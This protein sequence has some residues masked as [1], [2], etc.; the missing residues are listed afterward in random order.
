MNR[1]FLSWALVGALIAVLSCAG[2]RT[3]DAQDGRSAPRQGGAMRAACGKDMQSLC[4]GLAGKDAAKCLMKEHR[5]QL[6]AECLTF[7]KEARARRNATQAGAAPPPSG[8][9]NNPAPGA[10]E[11]VSQH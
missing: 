3:A 9:A 2:P 5:V 7:F 8:P 6:S 1:R 10:S 4:P 11:G